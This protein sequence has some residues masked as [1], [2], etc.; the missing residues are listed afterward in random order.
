MSR[1]YFTENLSDETIADMIDKALRFEKTVKTKNIKSNLL[2]MIPAAAAIALVIGLINLLPALLSNNDI[3]LP[4]GDVNYPGVYTGAAH[5]PGEEIELFVPW[6]M[7]KTF[8]EERVSDVMPEGRDKTKVL[9]YYTLKDPSAAE[10]TDRAREEMLEAYPFTQAAPMYVLDPNIGARE[11][12]QLLEL[13]TEYTNLTGIDIIK[14]YR[15]HG[16]ETTENRHTFDDPYPHVRFGATRD[17]LLLDIEWHTY[18]TWLE[19]IEAYRNWADENNTVMAEKMGENIRDKKLYK[20]KL[21]NGKKAVGFVFR[22]LEDM[23]NSIQVGNGTYDVDISQY[24][25]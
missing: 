13:F 24:L 10:L 17:I 25:D 3:G 23:Y 16:I 8:F 5:N 21:I 7:E 19:E 15:K 6:F 1:E 18:E 20:A 2:K 9:A 4:N 11:K 12:E 14:M 22:Q